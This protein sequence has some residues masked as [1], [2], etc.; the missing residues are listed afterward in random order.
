VGHVPLNWLENILD[1]V[2]VILKSVTLET[3]FIVALGNYAEVYFDSFGLVDFCVVGFL[4]DVVDDRRHFELVVFQAFFNDVDFVHLFN[5]E[6]V[7][8]DL[9][10]TDLLE[11]KIESMRVLSV[12]FGPFKF[13]MAVVDFFGEGLAYHVLGDFKLDVHAFVT[14]KNDT[15]LTVV[16]GDFVGQFFEKLKAT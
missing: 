11:C 4:V 10:G 9:F 6:K 2:F 16:G 14:Q 8:N 3:S 1:N 15:L 12:Q 7:C 5:T 13:F